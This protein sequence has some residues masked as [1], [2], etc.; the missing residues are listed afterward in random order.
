MDTFATTPKIK[1]A[2]VTGA[3]PFDVPGFH[4]L[5]RALD[6]LDVYVQS[7]DDFASD[8]GK[9]RER[10]DV[11]VLYHMVTTTPPESADGQPWYQ[12][13]HREA[14][15]KLGETPQGI[16]VLHHALLA[17][18]DWPHWSALVGM[19]DRRISSY[20]HQQQIPVRVAADHPITRGVPDWELSDETYVMHEAQPEHGNT[21]LLTTD[22]ERSTRTLAWTRQYRQS[23]VFCLQSGHDHECWEDERFRTVLQNGV[24]WCAGRG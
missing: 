2:V 8:V 11:V 13:R 21:V 6:D 18:P 10:Y 14:M 24:R 5:W 1:T 9:V 15:E 17:Y 22:H 19:E 20:H 3:H 16:V 4:R 7:L 23:R 12:R